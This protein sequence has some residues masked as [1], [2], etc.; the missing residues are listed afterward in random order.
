MN[1]DPIRVIKEDKIYKPRELAPQQVPKHLKKL[2][3]HKT[4]Y[5]EVTKCQ[6]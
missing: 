6:T 4:K 3:E 5:T 1:S 2:A